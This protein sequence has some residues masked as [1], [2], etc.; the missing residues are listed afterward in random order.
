M[1]TPEE[2]QNLGREARRYL[3]ARHGGVLST[4]SVK[5]AGYPFG[6]V[7]PFALD[8]QGCPLILISRLAEHTRNIAADA[9]CSLI[10]Q[11]PGIEDLQAAARLTCIAD[12][13]QVSEGDVPGVQSR[14]LRFFPGA[15][16]LLGLGDFSFRRLRVKALRFIGGFG[17]IHW[18]SA[19]DYAPPVNSLAEAEQSI[20]DH[21][22]N[23][24]AHNVADYCR[25]YLGTQT[26][27]MMIGVDCDGI[28]LRLGGKERGELRRIDFDRTVH[29][30]NEARAAL[31]AMAK[32]ARGEAPAE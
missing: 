30:A 17:K 10:V 6:S 12:A 18:V 31:V 14:Y 2:P 20:L 15:Q 4:T 29:D 1:N 13:E 25:H 8:Q 28:D 22:N 32:T 23:D 11:E 27:A 3:R 5:F 19:E 7:V 16:Q 21:M 24:H 26:E 9:R